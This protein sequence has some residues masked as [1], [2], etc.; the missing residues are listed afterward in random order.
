MKISEINQCTF[1]QSA[2]TEVSDLRP[3]LT[4]LLKKL[5]NMIFTFRYRF[6]YNIFRVGSAKK[7]TI[8]Q[9][10]KFDLHPGDWVE[11]CSIREIASTLDFHGKNKG[12][13]FM[14]E[15]EKYCGKQYRI[16]KIAEK[17]KLENNG[18]LR[19]LRQPGYFLEGVF[20]DG[21]YQGGCDRS[22]FHFWRYVW[23]KKMT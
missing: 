10:S 12:L 3:Y 23:L 22:C 16:F 19:K 9:E 8:V 4:R 17:I 18:Q 1:Q 2:L 20:C 15:M 11:I 21:Q 7:S 6:K 14:P 5:V 13:Y